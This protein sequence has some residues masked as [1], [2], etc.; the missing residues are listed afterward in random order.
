MLMI[1][2]KPRV[3]EIFG[4]LDVEHQRVQIGDQF[5]KRSYMAKLL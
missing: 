3:G 5:L 1:S 4:F 2:V